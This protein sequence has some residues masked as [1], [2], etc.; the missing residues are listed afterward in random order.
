MDRAMSRNPCLDAVLAELAAAGVHHP[1]LVPG[2]KHLQ[3]RWN[4]GTIAP[5]HE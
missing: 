4:R 1:V 5:L 3:A 2:A